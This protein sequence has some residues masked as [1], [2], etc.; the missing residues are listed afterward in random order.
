MKRL[1]GLKLVNLLVTNFTELKV[2]KNQEDQTL[3]LGRSPCRPRRAEVPSHRAPVPARA[4]EH[5][6]ESGVPV[7]GILLPKS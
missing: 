6:W 4:Q 7:Y 1:N 5:L 3:G 2:V